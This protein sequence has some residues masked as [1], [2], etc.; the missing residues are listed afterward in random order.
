M[1]LLFSF[2]INAN[3]KNEFYKPKLIMQSYYQGF[4]LNYPDQSISVS[5]PEFKVIPITYMSEELRPVHPKRHKHKHRQEQK[6][7]H[8]ILVTFD[9]PKK[10][11]RRSMTRVG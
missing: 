6:K 2:L 3:G 7:H 8:G 1:P 5:E 10:G 4:H 11:H 9:D